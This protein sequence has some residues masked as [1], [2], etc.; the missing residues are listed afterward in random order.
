MTSTL[1][2]RVGPLPWGPWGRDLLPQE[3]RPLATD[4]ACGVTSRAGCFS[5]PGIFSA[6]V[7]CHLSL[8]NRLCQMGR[9][10]LEDTGSPHK[11][12]GV[13]GRASLCASCLCLL[14]APGRV[15]A[16]GW[17]AGGCLSSGGPYFSQGSWWVGGGMDL[18]ALGPHPMK[19]LLVPWQ[20]CSKYRRAWNLPREVCPVR[21]PCGLQGSHVRDRT[22]M[23]FAK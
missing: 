8:L 6:S 20:G 1:A 4:Q 3:T 23:E 17:A 22:L 18:A 13:C 10:R 9:L 11:D 2:P 15:Q 12:T 7:T 5:P 19:I 21:R 14:R 16:E